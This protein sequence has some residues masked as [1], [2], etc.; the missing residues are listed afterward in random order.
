[1]KHKFIGENDYG[2]IE[3]TVKGLGSGRVHVRLGAGSNTRALTADLTPATAR[4]MAHAMLMEVEP[5][6]ENA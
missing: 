4:R 2:S 3:V 6:E 5:E 1:M